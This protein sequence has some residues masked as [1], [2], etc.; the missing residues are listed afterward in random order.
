[1]KKDNFLLFSGY[2]YLNVPKMKYDFIFVDGPNYK[3]QDG[4]SCSFDVIFI[5]KNFTNYFD[6]IIEKRL[7][8]V[9]IMQ[10]LLG[11]KAVKLSFVNRTSFLKVNISNSKIE[12]LPRPENL[13]QIKNISVN[14]IKPT[15]V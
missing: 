9:Y 14:L 8:T 11:K 5:L 2:R 3:D 13:I 15:L 4:M 12:K 1:M 6:C 7:S 10:K